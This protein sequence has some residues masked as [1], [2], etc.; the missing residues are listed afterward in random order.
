MTKKIVAYKGFNKDWTC[1]DFQ[2]EVGKTYKHD[3]DVN[4]CNSGFHAC[5]SPFDV[6]SYYGVFESKFAEVELSGDTATH[7]DD[8]KI[9]AAEITIKAEI[10]L[11]E[12]VNRGVDWILS[13]IID[14]KKE[15][16]TGYQSA[17]TNT[18]YQSAATNTG[19]QSAATNTGYQSA[20]T[21]TGHQSAATNTGH[22]SAAT[23]T[24]HQSAATNT[25]HQSAATN[26]GDQSAAT[27]TGYQSAA[28]NTGDQ[29]AATVEG[30]NSIAV[31]SG[32]GAKARASKGSGIVLCEY[33][34]DG[35]LKKVHSGIAGRGKIN[36]DTWYKAEGG[37]LVA[38]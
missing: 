30:E 17:A 1:R 16:N 26:T 7:D 8:S 15:A 18:G 28:T 23:N 27:N 19:D 9:A 2:Y 3:G 21:N 11:P 10:S 37:K 29:S 4:I 6:W 31:A 36:P 24:G 32:I 38:A 14:S 5:E 13:N 25:G 33:D 22:R 20:A 35:N 34:D 12:F